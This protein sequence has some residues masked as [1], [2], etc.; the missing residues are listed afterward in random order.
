MALSCMQ[1]SHFTQCR[2]VQPWTARA[3]ETNVHQMLKKTSALLLL[4]RAP[5]QILVQ[6]LM[7]IDVK[8]HYY[9]TIKFKMAEGAK[10]FLTCLFKIINFNKKTLL[11]ACHPITNKIHKEFNN[12]TGPW[13]L[14]QKNM[15]CPGITLMYLTLSGWSFHF[16]Q[17]LYNGLLTPMF[18][19][20]GN[21][22][23]WKCSLS[24]CVQY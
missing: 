7:A 17:L 16:I 11:L 22:L 6:I 12:F 19:L 10:A 24:L 20:K 21:K 1:M 2:V 18:P 13:H 8:L 5:Q 9:C 4:V 15:E 14:F 3:R 23:V